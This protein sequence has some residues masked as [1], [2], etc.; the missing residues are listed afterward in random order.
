MAAIQQ[1]TC[2]TPTEWSLVV[3]LQNS[4]GSR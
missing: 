4:L 2:R 3:S 1:E